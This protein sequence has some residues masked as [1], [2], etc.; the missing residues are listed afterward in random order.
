M[1]RTMLLGAFAIAALLVSSCT[2]WGVRAQS[3][4]CNTSGHCQV[5]VTVN[6]DGSSCTF[7]PVGVITVGPGHKPDIVWTIQNTGSVQ[8]HF[9]AGGIQFNNKADPV[10]ADE[11]DDKGVQASGAGYRMKD[12]HKTSGKQY[13]YKITVKPASGAA[14]E[15][16]PIVANE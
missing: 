7:T 16:D 10:P 5:T 15:N 2:S 9:E 11:F 12:Q 1:K 13:N 4:S 14:C 3:T 8:Y 6:G